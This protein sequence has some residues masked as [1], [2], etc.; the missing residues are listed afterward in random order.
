MENELFRKKSLE[1][2]S[3]PEELH[4]YMRVTTPRLWMIL[5]AIILLLVGFIVYASS[6]KM[7]N[8]MSIRV[9]VMSFNILEEAQK[10]TGQT[11]YSLVSSQLPVTLADTVDTG[12]EVRIGTYRGKVSWIGESSDAEHLSVMIEMENGY[13]PLPDGSYDAELVLE[14]AT[15]ISFL[16][17]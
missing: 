17:N 6:A 8:L 7:E 10:E 4:D 11:R 9:E 15:P 5:G 3:S 2:I 16:W 12:M 1:K 13:V 14:S